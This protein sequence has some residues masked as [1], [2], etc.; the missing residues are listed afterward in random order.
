[1]KKSKKGAITILMLGMP[2]FIFGMKELYQ[3][4]RFVTRGERADGVIVA[5]KKHQGVGGKYFP[6]VRFQTKDG[7]TINFTPGNGSNPPMYKL[8]DHVPVIYNNDYPNTAV[9]NSFIEIWLAPV[10]YV[11]LGL[12]LLIF[13]GFQWARSEL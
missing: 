4:N 2:F 7:K 1:M 12:L 9:I 3:V 6:L 13:S 8:F 5:M 11:G 10:V